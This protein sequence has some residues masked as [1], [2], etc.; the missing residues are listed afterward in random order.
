M[1]DK[2]SSP[3]P[4]RLWLKRLFSILLLIV[5]MDALLFGAAGRLDWFGAWLLDRAVPGFPAGGR[6]LRRPP[7]AGA[8]SK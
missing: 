7:H 8:L 4:L 2:S 3:V 5:I 1:M 6:G